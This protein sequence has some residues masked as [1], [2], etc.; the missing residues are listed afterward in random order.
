MNDATNEITEMDPDNE[1]TI[2]MQKKSSYKKCDN[3]V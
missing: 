3:T 2:T 1:R